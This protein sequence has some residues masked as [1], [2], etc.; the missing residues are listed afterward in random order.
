MK[1]L[2]VQIVLLAAGGILSLL[3][4]I[5]GFSGMAFQIKNGWDEH[6]P[7]IEET[8]CF[9]FC[10]GIVSFCTTITLLNLIHWAFFEDKPETK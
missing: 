2:A 9:F 8:A 5:E 3:L 10:I 7:A 6:N 4:L 1:K